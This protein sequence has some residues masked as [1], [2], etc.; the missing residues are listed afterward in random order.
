M[1]VQEI[2]VN[3]L[4]MEG[5]P[6]VFSKSYEYE[7]KGMYQKAIDVLMEVYDKNNYMINMRLGYLY[8]MLK[9]NSESAGYYLNAVNLMP[10]SIEA[11][12]GYITPLAATEDWTKVIEKYYEIL[13]IDPQNTTANYKL[14]LIYYYQPDYEKAYKCFE[15]VVNLYPFDLYGNLMFAWANLKLGKTAEA[16]SLF[17]R[18]L[19][20]NPSETSA[21]EGLALIK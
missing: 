1:P 9:S 16:K 18:T 15:K 10:Y 8:Y 19:C 3:K 21:K 4:N 20:I 12:F 11:K 5:L 13:S 2:F 7:Y 14:G 6:D 17:E